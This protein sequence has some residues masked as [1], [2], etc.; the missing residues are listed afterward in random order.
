MSF[1]IKKYLTETSELFRWFWKTYP[2]IIE[3]HGFGEQ[4]LHDAFL[5][6]GTL[7]EMSICLME[8]WFTNQEDHFL[9]KE[10]LFTAFKTFWSLYGIEHVKNSASGLLSST[11]RFNKQREN[12]LFSKEACV[13]ILLN[14]EHFNKL[15]QSVGKMLEDQIKYHYWLDASLYHKQAL[16]RYENSPSLPRTNMAEHQRRL[17]IA[18]S[19]VKRCESE[20]PQIL[21]KDFCAKIYD[22]QK[23][24]GISEI[25]NELVCTFCPDCNR[26]MEMQIYQTLKK[27]ETCECPNCHKLFLPIDKPQRYSFADTK[28]DPVWQLK[29]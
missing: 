4:L 29:N 17:E 12:L 10:V 21:G 27:F 7:D 15:Q 24:A 26:Q 1:F 8:F 6:T 3:K 28:T 19:L 2:L 16:Q 18:N 23:V 20:G 11:E 25:K 5:K 14:I 9:K 13:E 22:Y